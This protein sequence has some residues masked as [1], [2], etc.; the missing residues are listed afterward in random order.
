MHPLL[1]EVILGL[2]LLAAISL[3]VYEVFQQPV[4]IIKQVSVA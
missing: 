4:L 1:L 3:V 2:T